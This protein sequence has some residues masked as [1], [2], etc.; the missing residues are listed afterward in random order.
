M[1]STSRTFLTQEEL[2]SLAEALEEIGDAV[3]KGQGPSTHMCDGVYVTPKAWA[4]RC[5]K[6]EGHYPKT[7]HYNP[8]VGAWRVATTIAMHPELGEPYV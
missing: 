4:Y 5:M 8:R 2:D 3:S 7:P 6:P 1:R